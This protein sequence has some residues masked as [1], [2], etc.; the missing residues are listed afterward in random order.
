MSEELLRWRDADSRPLWVTETLRVGKPPEGFIPT[1]L[2][3]RS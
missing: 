3:L 2:T 1:L